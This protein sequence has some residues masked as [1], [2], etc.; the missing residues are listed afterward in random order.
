[1]KTLRCSCCDKSV[2]Y[3][4]T[5]ETDAAGWTAIPNTADGLVFE[6]TCPTHSEELKS[7]MRHILRLFPTKAAD[8]HFHALLRRMMRE[9]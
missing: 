3:V 2:E 9:A 7:A 8:L 1:M 5:R 6:Y 4:E